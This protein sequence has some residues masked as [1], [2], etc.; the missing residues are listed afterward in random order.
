MIFK[1]YAI[2]CLTLVLLAAL[3]AC[4]EG[5]AD[6]YLGTALDEANDPAKLDTTKY[7]AE[8]LLYSTVKI[9]GV[10]PIESKF[11]EFVKVVGKPD[12]VVAV[13]EDQ[14]II[15]DRSYQEIHYKGSLFYKL[16]DT[17]VFQTINFRRGNDLEL[18]SPAI[19]LNNKTTLEDV[20][21]LFPKAVSKIRTLNS[22]EFGPLRLVAFGASKEIVEVWWILYFADGKLVLAEMFS[23][24]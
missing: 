9:N 12:S 7:N 16:G 14:C 13:G 17:A 5:K 2:G 24:C 21:K 6:K 8:Y 18:T 20:Q 10:L 22:D 19:T 4:N 23:D 3:N 11:A 1:K 15:Y